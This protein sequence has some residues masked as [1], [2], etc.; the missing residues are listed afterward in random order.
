L[1]SVFDRLLVPSIVPCPIGKLLTE[2]DPESATNLRN[3]L[4]LPF[5]DLPNAEI[6]RA[7]LDE[8]KITTSV[9]TISAHRKGVCRCT[10]P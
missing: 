3:A 1:A 2:T 10:T 7:I 8:A 4:A 5:A 9:E 6:R